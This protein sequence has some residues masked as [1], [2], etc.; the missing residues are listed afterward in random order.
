[1]RDVKLQCERDC[2][3]LLRKSTKEQWEED[4]TTLGVAK[5]ISMDAAIT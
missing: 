3:Q 4:A 2:A 5:K 1:M